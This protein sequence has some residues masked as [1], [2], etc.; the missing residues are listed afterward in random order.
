MTWAR[1]AVLGAVL[2]A[3]VLMV[4]SPAAAVL[5]QCDFETYEGY[6]TGAL[7]GQNGWLADEDTVVQTA[8]AS[9]GLQALEMVAHKAEYTGFFDL[10]AMRSLVGVPGADPVIAISQDVRLSA[11]D[12]ADWRVSTFYGLFLTETNRVHFD[13]GG[14]ILVNNVDTGYDWA[15]DSWQTLDMVLDFD[16]GQMDVFYGGTLVANDV[17]FMGSN[18]GVSALM[19]STDNNVSGSSTMYYDNLKVG[20]IPEPAATGLGL[21]AAALAALWDRRRRS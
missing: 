4:S 19:V 2:G 1:M 11:R 5:Y 17:E 18:A 10:M 3:V 9:S 14:D 8:L 15:V 20:V 6:S 12:D 7:A 21:V 16:A 13:G